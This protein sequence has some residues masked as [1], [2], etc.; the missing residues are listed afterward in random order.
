MIGAWIPWSDKS[1]VSRWT[2]YLIEE[3]GC[4]TWTGGRN[5]KGYGVVK[6][7][8]RHCFVHRVR[9]EREIG[10][11]P[12]GLVLDHYAC[13]N[14]A[15]GCCNPRHCRPVT[16][17]ENNLRSD[18]VSGVNAGKTHCPRGHELVHPN[19]VPSFW[20]RGERSCRTCYNEI[21]YAANRKRRG[22][23]V[24]PY[25]Q[26]RGYRTKERVLARAKEILGC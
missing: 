6:N 2:G 10:P 25:D 17:R 5:W 14:G 3:N 20:R 1:G 11:I 9:Y 22:A 18:C 15:G 21:M 4:H 16:T 12:D 24:V 19:L 8:G 7:A 13:S 23:P 26:R